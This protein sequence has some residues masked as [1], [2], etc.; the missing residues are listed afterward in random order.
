MEEKKRIEWS[1]FDLFCILRFILRYFWMVIVGALTAVMAVYLVQGLAMT[2]TYT[3]SVT[4][5]LTSRNS[6]N[7]TSVTVAATDTVAEQF[8]TLISSDLVR[9]AAAE[10][11]GMS[12]FPATVSVSV[13][14]NT[15]ILIM[16]LTADTPELAYKSALAIM[17]THGAYSQNIFSSMVLDNINGP[18]IS[19]TPNGSSSRSKLLT[20]SAPIGALLM[21][22]LLVMMS[23]QADT[24]QTPS[25]A[26]RQID[27]KLLTTIYHERKNRTLQSLW[28]R[29]KSSLLITNPTISFYYTETI[30]QLR[31]FLERAHEKQG[32]Q[33]FVVTSCSE[34]E[35][36]S[37]VAANIALS[38]AEKHHRVLLLDADLRKP[39]QHL[40]FEYPVE[41]GKDF[42]ALMVKGFTDQSLK[43]AVV[44]LDH[45][46]L[47]VLFAESVRRHRAETFSPDSFRPIL[48]ALR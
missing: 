9:Q 45:C 21:I 3:S 40:V 34:N 29:K 39:A 43:D 36:K 41:N 42:G 5:S 37:T 6:V 46:N 25:G 10:R 48:E 12:S 31:V 20:F 7:S 35:G 28:K 8:A 13:P 26:K 16:D 1:D 33:V 4:F 19:T 2:P 11:M 22:V 47:S 38:L 17:D 30:H 15:N 14:E 44:R 18:T 27:G 23:I 24:V 32:K